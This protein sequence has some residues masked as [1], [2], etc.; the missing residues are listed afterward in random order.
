MKRTF[1]VLGCIV[2]L[3]CLC[4]GIES[5]LG[6]K[7]IT[8]GTNIT[9]SPT[10]GTGNVTVTGTTFSTSTV[11]AIKAGTNITVSPANGAGGDVTINSTGGGLP[12]TTTFYFELGSGGDVY[13]SSNSFEA[14]PGVYYTAVSTYVIT[15]YQA[16]NIVASTVSV[17]KYNIAYTSSTGST[18]EYS[19]PTTDLSVNQNSKYSAWV[20]TRIAINFQ[21]SIAVH[22][23]SVPTQGTLPAAWGMRFKAWRFWKAD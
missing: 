9:V 6:V 23:T 1:A 2:F 20:S 3:N 5:E 7:K 8:A 10:G 21:D 22:I 14:S 12:D 18:I 15:A 16:F 4:F 13:V 19:Y 11:L 17:T